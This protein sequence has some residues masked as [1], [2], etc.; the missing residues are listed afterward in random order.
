MS[1][2][3]NTEHKMERYCEVK[4]KQLK[5]QDCGGKV[6]LMTIGYSIRKGHGMLCRNCK[7]Q[8]ITGGTPIYAGRIL[9][10]YN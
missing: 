2:H 8:R 1:E 7:I 6:L 9:P 10:K 5:C 3:K 4:S